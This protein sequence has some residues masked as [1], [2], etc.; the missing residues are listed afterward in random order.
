M[1]TLRDPAAWKASRCKA[2]G[3]RPQ[4]QADGPDQPGPDDPT[5]MGTTAQA[6]REPQRVRSADYW[7]HPVAADSDAVPAAK[8]NK[9]AW[10]DGDQ[11]ASPT[12]A[13]LATP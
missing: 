8:V 1:A 10:S 13:W 2:G 4:Q 6:R 3:T 11:P 12:A 7:V 5:A 9:E